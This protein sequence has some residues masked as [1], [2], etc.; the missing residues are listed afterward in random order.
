MQ[1]LAV[2]LPQTESEP[3]A[4]YDRA[5]AAVV[6]AVQRSGFPH[7]AITSSLATLMGR[8]LDSDLNEDEMRIV[9]AALSA[10]IDDRWHPV[11]TP[12]QVRA[13]LQTGFDADRGEDAIRDIRLVDGD[14]PVH[15]EEHARRMDRQAATSRS[16]ARV[17]W[18]QVR[19]LTRVVSRRRFLPSTQ[20]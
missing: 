14:C 8:L 18:A 2:P 16:S 3:I 4:V 12:D 20:A 15:I 5:H 10:V 9:E 6:A 17:L 1:T 11:A 13:V 19:K 7:R